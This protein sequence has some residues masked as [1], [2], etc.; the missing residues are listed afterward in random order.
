[1]AL[2]PSTPP[3][4][5][6]TAGVSHTNTHAGMQ[7]DGQTQTQT[8]HTAGMESMN[9]DIQLQPDTQTHSI[10]RTSITYTHNSSEIHK[11]E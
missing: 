7:L 10:R 5:C 4:V 9:T 3:L 2:S 8:A 1:M 11:H 6:S